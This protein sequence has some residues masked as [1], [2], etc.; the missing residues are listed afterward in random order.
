MIAGTSRSIYVALMVALTVAADDDEDDVED[1]AERAPVSRVVIEAGGRRFTGALVIDTYS[2][3]ATMPGV[4]RIVTAAD[5]PGQRWQGLIYRDWPIFVAEGETTRFVGDV[6]QERVVADH[7]GPRVE[8]HAVGGAPVA[9]RAR[10]T[11]RP[12]AVPTVSAMP[13]RKEETWCSWRGRA[14]RIV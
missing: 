14:R 11:R 4:V 5:V 2:A 3:A 9:P 10:G 6:L 8:E 7:V 1:A 13:T 12:P